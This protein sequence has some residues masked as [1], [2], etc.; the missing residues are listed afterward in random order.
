MPRTPRP[1]VARGSDPVSARALPARAAPTEHQETAKR[2]ARSLV[3]LAALAA[4]PA[5]LAQVA[6]IDP[7]VRGTVPAQ[8]VTGA[9]MQLKSATDVALVGVSSPAA[10]VAEIH[11]MKMEGGVMRMSAVKRID[12]AAGQVVDLKPGGYHV[13]LMDLKA[14]ARE[15]DKL[16]VTLTFQDKAGKRFTMDVQAP[17]RALAAAPAH[18]TH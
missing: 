3:L 7:W 13:M 17:V 9:F 6:V 14:Q 16:P 10:G 11:E 15:G 18:P 4:A 1:Q 12:L 5:A 8:K 2:F